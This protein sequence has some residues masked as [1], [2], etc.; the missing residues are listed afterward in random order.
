MGRN[1]L[2][3]RGMLPEDS[4]LVETAY[5]TACCK[6]QF[7]EVIVTTGLSKPHAWSHLTTFFFSFLI[8]E[9]DWLYL[10]EDRAIHIVVHY[11]DGEWVYTLSDGT[12]I[13]ALPWR[14]PAV[15]ITG[16]Q[17]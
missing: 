15:L 4:Y 3:R 16:R 10:L 1:A 11:D 13:I 14:S 5:L 12:L 7:P 2:G 6:D 17:Y 8:L 9:N